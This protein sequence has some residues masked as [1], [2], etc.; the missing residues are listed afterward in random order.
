MLINR[1]LD[2]VS[3]DTGSL[4][5]SETFPSTPGQWELASHL[6]DELMDLGLQDIILDE[7]CYV[8]AYLPGDP[9]YLT[10]GFNAHMD[11]SD[12]ASGK[13]VKP[14]I[15]ENYD[16]NDIA[17]N[18][19]LSTTV[20]RFPNLK[21][22]VGKTLVVTDGTTLLGADDKAG[23]ACI[24]EMLERLI[25]N[26]RI[27]HGPIRVCFSPDE[28]IGRGTEHF[29]YDRFQVD[30]AYTV[31]GDK[32]NRIEY[33]NFNAASAKVKI[34]GISVAKVKINGISVHPGSA[35]NKM[36]NA[37]QVAHEFHGMLDPE[38]VPEKTEGYEG[39]NL[40]MGL[41][42]EV[43]NAQMSYIIRNH[44]LDLLN[45]QK[46]DFEVIRDKL[47]EKYGYP[48]VELELTDSYRN[49]KEKFIG[50]DR[51]IQLVRQAMAELDLDFQAV[52]IR[53]GTD[54]AALTWH[55]ILCPNLGTGGRS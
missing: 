18:E 1:F 28:E 35:K 51:P 31:D 27:K 16:G 46:H 4:E 30:F 41:K 11:T 55:G 50:N 37:L 9:D 36:V 39:F 29:D 32:P 45:R 7:Y 26:P 52:A 22:Y 17:L 53:G 49:M 42:G 20:E 10:I 6:R 14:R 23:I 2:Y 40:L 47:N 5:E 38:A 19:E 3:Y 8:Y 54:G 25:R 21:D 33:E 48:V 43:A 44:D 12:Q 24:M 13:G 15:I 34:N